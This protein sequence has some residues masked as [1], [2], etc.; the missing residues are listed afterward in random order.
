M[1]D[2]GRVESC[3]ALVPATT[4]LGRYFGACRR[5]LMAGRDAL[6]GRL[7]ESAAGYR[8]AAGILRDLDVPLELGYCLLESATLIGPDDPAARAAGAEAREIFTT[9]GSPPLLARLDVG[10]ARWTKGGG[11]ATARRVSV[12]TATPP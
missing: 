10:L 9:L 11:R 2:A 6:E 1:E 7:E 4:S 3:L 8:T 12:K 5:T